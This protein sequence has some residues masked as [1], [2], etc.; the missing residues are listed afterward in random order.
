MNVFAC[1]SFGVPSLWLRAGFKWLVE[2]VV[3]IT[4]KRHLYQLVQ[5]A[6]YKRRSRFRYQLCREFSEPLIDVA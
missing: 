6:A 1:K 3:K 2:F 5:T 4:K